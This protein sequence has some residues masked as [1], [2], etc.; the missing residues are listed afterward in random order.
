MM[1]IPDINAVRDWCIGM[2]AKKA[3][4]PTKLSGLTNDKGFLTE[5]PA[6]TLQRMGAVKPDGTTIVI[7]AD[8][9][10]S[11]VGGGDSGGTG[12]VHL[13]EGPVNGLGLQLVNPEDIFE[14]EE[15]S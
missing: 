1:K 8:G 9:T 12:P 15:E 6:A 4:V 10:I 11:A 2:F 3:E 14:V 5:M 7:S 13:L